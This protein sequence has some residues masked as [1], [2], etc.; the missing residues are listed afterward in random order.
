MGLRR[1]GAIAS[2]SS[3]ASNSGFASDFRR[4]LL[5]PTNFPQSPLPARDGISNGSSRENLDGPRSCAK[6]LGAWILGAGDQTPGDLDRQIGIVIGHLLADLA[7]LECENAL[8]VVLHADRSPT[9][10]ESK[11]LADGGLRH[12]LLGAQ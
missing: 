6:K 5:I 10:S 8:P 12:A 1:T 11:T 9:F 3:V 7:M 2:Y 4:I